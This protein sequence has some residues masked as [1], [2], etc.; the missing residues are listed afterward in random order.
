MYAGTS[1]GT[2]LTSS[3]VKH[4]SLVKGAILGPLHSILW[5]LF[6][7]AK[8]LH[9][10]YFV[11]SV[12]LLVAWVII[13]L[14]FVADTI[15]WDSWY[16]NIPLVSSH[17]KFTAKVLHFTRFGGLLCCM[18]LIP[19]QTL[20]VPSREAHGLLVNESKDVPIPSTLVNCIFG[21]KSTS[22][23]CPSWAN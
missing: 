3:V 19:L 18:E 10:L 13:P 17:S 2:L 16:D 14:L 1:P 23:G 7:T 6:V 21:C 15:L 5:D 8:V 4:L 22:W 9:S 11:E 12:C 20:L